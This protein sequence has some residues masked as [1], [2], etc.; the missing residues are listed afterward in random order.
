M[1]R[2]AKRVLSLALALIM[3]FGLVPMLG[4]GAVAASG[5]DVASVPQ[6]RSVTSGSGT[7]TLTDSARFFIVSDSDPTDTPLG[8][9]V[10]TVSSEFAAKGLPSGSVLPVVYGKESSIADG[11]IVIRVD[12]SVGH[13]QG[14]SM[15]VNEKNITITGNDELGVIYGLH[16]VLQSMV[17]G[18]VTLNGCTVSDWPDV[19]ERS[20]YLDC[21]RIYFKPDTIKALIRTLSWNK[22]NTLYL[23]F[24]NNNATRFFLDKMNV[25]VDGTTYD[26]TSA[27]PSDG[28]I[29]QSEMDGI[30]AEAKKYGVDI[31]PTFNSPGHIGGIQ[32]VNS[33]FFK[34]AGA[35]DYDSGTGKVAL[36]ILDSSAY[37]FGQEVVKLYVDYFVSKGCKS[38]NI[39]ADEVTDAISGLNSTNSTF[40][41]YVN[42][43][44]T[45]IKEQSKNTM[46]TRMFNDGYKSTSDGIDKD[47][48]IIYWTT[49]SPNAQALIDEGHNVVNM[50]C[51]A[52]LYYA[53][54]YGIS[55]AYVWNQDVDKIYAG[56]NPGVTS[57]TVY[58]WGTSSYNYTPQEWVTDYTNEEKLL[59][60]AFAIWTDYAFNRGKDGTTIFAE[61]YKNMMQKIYTVAERSWST[62]CTDAYSTW[63]A[64]LKAVP[65]GLTMSGSVDTTTLPTPSAITSVEPEV[66]TGYVTV[67]GKPLTSICLFTG[68]DTEIEF[69]G[70]E[71]GQSIAV[72]SEN[73]EVATAAVEGS[74]ITLT[75]VSKGTTSIVTTVHNSAAR[76]IADGE[77]FTLGIT[78]YDASEGLPIENVPEYT[79]G[80]V[81]TTPG[82][83]VT[84]Y[85]L[86]TDGVD[87]GAYYLIV[88]P[89]S[90]YALL[91]NNSSVSRASVT[92]NGN[93]AEIASSDEANARWKI[94]N[95][96]Y[97]TITNNNSYLYLYTRGNNA[98]LN[99][100]SGG[101]NWTISNQSNGYY[102]FSSSNGR[103]TY[104]LVYS[105]NTFT[106]ST[107]AS[108]L[109]LYKQTTTEGKDAY[110]V[111][112][113][114]LDKLLAYAKG[115]NSGDFSNWN[116]LDI[117]SLIAAAEAAKNAVA[118]PYDAQTDA[119]TAQDAVN[120]AG[121]NL[122]DALAQLKYKA[123][124][125]I[126]VKCVDENGNA[127]GNGDYVFRA[128]DNG[129]GGYDYKITA[130]E[131]SGYEYSSGALTGTVTEATEIT[132]VYTEK[133]FSIENSIEIPI[134]II[135][136]RAD[137][138]LFDHNIFDNS[139]GYSLVHTKYGDTYTSA[140]TAINGTSLE[141][142]PYGGHRKND[143][144]FPGTTYAYNETNAKTYWNNGYL[145]LLGCFVRTG[146]VEDNLGNDGM[147][148]YTEATVKY[149]AE[150]LA[151]GV[152]NS[153]AYNL[154]KFDNTNVYRNWNDILYNTF[155]KS[156]SDR[157]VL[158]TDTTGFSATFGVSKSYADISNAYDLAWYLLQNL[159]TADKNMAEV[160][161]N[162]TGNTY[163]L[164][165]YGM[166]TDV[167][168][169]LILS[170]KTENGE[171]YY[172]LDA[173]DSTSTRVVYDTE[174][175][176]IYMADD[177][178]DDY[179][180]FY[181]LSGYG[182][183]AYLGDTTDMQY[184]K[185]SSGYYPSNPNG[186]MTLRGEAQFVYKEADDLY[187]T[188]SGDDD[189][190]LYINGVL[191][192]DLGG[193][194]WPLVKTVNLN[195]VAAKC[196][197]QEGQIATF[198]FFYMERNAD[199]SNFSI[200]TNLTLAERGIEVAKDAYSQ[201]DVEIPDG[202]VVDNKSTVSYAFRV[203]NK[204]KG[205]TM[206]CISFVDTDTD[207]GSVSFG[208][209]ITDPVI[210]DT[211]A[212]VA[213]G[214]ASYELYVSN[215]AG[216]ELDGS[217]Q[218]FDNLKALSDAVGNVTLNPGETL[219]V[220]FLTATLNVPDVGIVDFTN[221]IAVTA[222]SG[223]Q[224]LTAS[225][226]H[227]IYSYNSNDTQRDY[228]VDFGIPMTATS[229]F[230]DTAKNYIANKAITIDSRTNLKYGTV[231]LTGTGF[232]TALTYTMNKRIEGI[233]SIVLD[234]T[235]DFGKNE[236][237]LQK[238]IRIIP[239]TT[240]YYEEDYVEF[241]GTNGTKWTEEGTQIANAVQK[242]DL[243]GDAQANVYGYD[244][245]YDKTAQYSLG[246]AMKYRAEGKEYGT[247]KFTFAGT[248][249]DIVGLTSGTTGAIVVRV[250]NDS[251]FKKNYMVDT[252]YGYTYNEDSGE[253]EVNKENADTLYQ[254]PVMKI[255]NLPY[256]TYTAT[257]T[258]AYGDLF[259]HT[260]IKYSD[261]YFDAVRIYDPAGAA[262]AENPSNVQNYI[263]G[264]YAEDGEGWPVY[265]ELRNMVIDAGTFEGGTTG[266]F[267]GIVFIDG[268][269]SVGT[270]V[271]TDYTSYGPNNELY[272]APGQAVAFNLVETGANIADV[273]V[274]MKATGGN[275]S[276]AIYNAGDANPESKPLE[277]ATDMYYSINALRGGTI[278]IQNTG[279]SGIISITNIKTTFTSKPEAAQS[280]V[281]SMNYA[282][283]KAAVA[284]VELVNSPAPAFEPARFDVSL[285]RKTVK[286]GQAVKVT[287]TTSSEVE[288]VTV[289]GEAVTDVRTSWFTGAKTWKI[290]VTADEAGEF[291]IDVVAFDA[292]GA[293]SE[294][295]TAVLNVTERLSFKD[296]FTKLF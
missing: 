79:P 37:T 28:W 112:T 176:A 47:I 233:E 282:S 99:I 120:N 94:S 159:Y 178:D 192:L 261:F 216:T 149:V 250:T 53:Y 220:R 276:Y 71:D 155:L 50:N 284:S 175:K 132:L 256:G 48:T 243:A 124:V 16:T 212:V 46:T 5:A 172:Y 285:S 290:Y 248:G 289:N 191:A 252:Y 70:L 238:I 269:P 197:L 249:F 253:W 246:S 23:D 174:N 279:E 272:L 60:A 209:G 91:N 133:S 128:I 51:H 110:T 257:V 32:S 296:W 22:M 54:C 204:G 89:D 58:N 186:S 96:S 218:T 265:A 62:S 113:S 9:Y 245:A 277:T 294:P 227:Q 145:L 223:G 135:D 127:L 224:T 274:G 152:C 254:V 210:A 44:N 136:Y 206:D 63:S 240:V 214:E 116:E 260:G 73:E 95:S 281:L 255:D 171:T 33:S 183:D 198:T 125:A 287:V 98:S 24:S 151:D 188:F 237:V 266:E 161:D 201:A 104:Y 244:G 3:V 146:L 141:F 45:Y 229:L 158:N 236:V 56:W 219:H 74:K 119:Q 92:I 121:Q 185:D 65:G 139:Y 69:A 26:I 291:D 55:S 86:D 72:R 131:I 259:D 164:P 231:E 108:N 283:A 13:E 41:S 258:A 160:T 251:G 27:K 42:D 211:S 275:A 2:T 76:T 18:G 208:Y 177:K 87:A 35:S 166:G 115:L 293:E 262:S 215:A 84:T 15:T 4:A 81:G 102:R 148:V 222:R 194:H 68:T 21:G 34:S 57:C 83:D 118:N 103:R 163:T 130:P 280:S 165:I 75:P 200:K 10:Q 140:S 273:M 36:N 129:N 157:S 134:S 109:R 195:D 85:V 82:E 295:V 288:A 40:V 101:T 221:K 203:T 80:T 11:D 100:S 6:A 241:T 278:V 173:Y 64:K 8:T 122:R 170:Q 14:Y 93:T 12:S 143:T 17:T 190:Y 182:Y 106:T 196:N 97:A 107:S 268:K 88:A 225:D 168:N 78:V 230:A 213:M 228:V 199:A 29:S 153:N 105:Y 67:D 167:Y 232:D 271:I 263:S 150:M 138:L 1:Q 111:D 184:G 207:G 189:V 162:N 142:L 30:I 38:F 19:S 144:T 217:R 264:V 193:A 235:Y 187:F 239:A 49:E 169:K 267:E 286:V 52:G 20:V 247:A 59:G 270:A 137:G 156:G 114:S 205:T 123:S 154:S 180:F 181:P 292:N 43:L 126:T 117:D 66:K 147:P 226:T 242:D 202:A 25:T 234:V 77:E 61:N 31:I 7:F 90:E 39:A 179:T